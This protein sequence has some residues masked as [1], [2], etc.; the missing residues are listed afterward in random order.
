MV[1]RNRGSELST[2]RVLYRARKRLLFQKQH[3]RF[4]PPLR[5]DAA[6][7][8]SLSNEDSLRFDSMRHHNSMCRTISSYGAFTSL[9]P[10]PV[11]PESPSDGVL[12]SGTGTF[13]TSVRGDFKHLSKRAT[14]SIKTAQGTVKNAGYVGTLRTNNLGLSS[15]VYFPSMPVRRLIG[16]RALLSV[17]WS[18]VFSNDGSSMQRFTADGTHHVIPIHETNQHLGIPKVLFTF[19]DEEVTNLA[20]FDRDGDDDSS[21]SLP[22]NSGDVNLECPM[23]DANLA[24][25]L[26]PK[27]VFLRHVR[28]C[29]IWKPSQGEG[30]LVCEACEINGRPRLRKARGHGFQTAAQRTRVGP[31][32]RWHIDHWSSPWRGLRNERQ[33]L[34]A[35]DGCTGFILQKSE[36]STSEAPDSLKG[37]AEQMRRAAGGYLLEN[38]FTEVKSDNDAVFTRNERMDAVLKEMQITHNSSEPFAP[39][40]NGIAENAIGTVSAKVYRVLFG[41]DKRL[42]THAA[43]HVVQIQ[44]SIS[45]VYENENRLDGL[46]PREAVAV[47]RRRMSYSS[48]EEATAEQL[49]KYPGRRVGDIDSIGGHLRRFGALCFVRVRPKGAKGSATAIPAVWLGVEPEMGACCRFGAWVR[50]KDEW[51]FSDA[52]RSSSYK[53]FVGNRGVSTGI[54]GWT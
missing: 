22:T 1:R 49:A 36:V 41:V 42:W 45:R 39:V 54:G 20:M 11:L 14:I 23:V 48:L 19:R 5:V 43:R 53:V 13:L 35:K 37:F 21:L 28:S 15:G 44:N 24:T 29:H 6:F 51:R 32:L 26:S 12:D 47:W 8:T 52:I 16:V 9:S 7:A 10:F 33:L 46:S 2:K 25:T 34:L 30:I 40:T 27:E 3:G 31:W 4:A 38:I 18:I 50:W 17:A